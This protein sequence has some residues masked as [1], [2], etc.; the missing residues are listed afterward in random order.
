[1]AVPVTVV[2]MTM[3]GMTVVTT[4]MLMLTAIITTMMGNSRA[5]RHRLRQQAPNRSP[6]GPAAHCPDCPRRLRNPHNNGLKQRRSGTDWL[7]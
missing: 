4:T 1:M 2:V 7:P 6:A 5:R 3:T